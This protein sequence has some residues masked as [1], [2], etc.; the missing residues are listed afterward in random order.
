M[1]NDLT[2]QMEAAVIHLAYRQH[3]EQGGS[4][5]PFRI[6]WRSAKTLQ[7]IETVKYRMCVTRLKRSFRIKS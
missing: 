6:R 4:P 5:E 1:P 2:K 7:V 3:I